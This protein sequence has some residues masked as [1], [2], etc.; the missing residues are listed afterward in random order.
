MRFSGAAPRSLRGSAAQGRRQARA[1]RR[2]R[3]RRVASEGV[4]SPPSPL[5][6]LG[7]G[8]S[9]VGRRRRSVSSYAPLPAPSS[10]ERAPSG[11]FCGACDA[12][13]APRRTV[14]L[15]GGLLRGLCALP[16]PRRAV[17]S[18]IQLMITNHDTD[19]P[20][21]P[22]RPVDAVIVAAS[23]E[24]VKGRAVDAISR[25][26]IDAASRED[27]ENNGARQRQTVRWAVTD[28]HTSRDG[29]R[30]KR[31]PGRRGQRF[32]CGGCAVGATLLGTYKFSKEPALQ[33]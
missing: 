8:I 27:N 7:G 22:S 2:R 24:D 10:G 23:L 13:D 12:G 9:I 11:G 15:A 26:R 16:R 33:T 25:P 1:A 3:G 14:G 32:L 28:P 21:P 30:R 4:L 18:R 19:I 20:P 5:G 6:P 31:P 29:P 17:E